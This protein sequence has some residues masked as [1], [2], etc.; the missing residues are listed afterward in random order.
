VAALPTQA[1]VRMSEVNR[2]VLFVVPSGTSFHTFF[3]S[4]ADAWRETGGDLAVAAGPDLPGQT[5]EWPEAVKRFPLPAF[6]GGNPWKLFAAGRRL[7]E[8]VTRWNP[9]IVHAHFAAGVVAAAVAKPVVGD[10][11]RRWVGTFHGLHMSMAGT[12]SVASRLTAT[13][14]RWAARRMDTVCVLNREDA[15][16]MRAILPRNRVH[17]VAS[18]GVG[19][20]LE[21][22]DPCHYP[23]KCRQDLR[24]RLGILPDSLVVAYVGRRTAFKGF[25]VAVRG[26]MRAGLE[27]A[28]LLLVGAPDDAHASGLSAA[29]RSTLAVDPRVVDAG[30]QWNVAP[31]LAVADICLLPSIREGLP[32][33][34]MEALAMG[35]PVVTIDARGCRDVV[36]DGIDGFVLPAAEADVIAN[37]LRTV[38][39][40]RDR[41]CRMATAAIAGRTRFDR[42]RYVAAELDLYSKELSLLDPHLSPQEVVAND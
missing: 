6:R 25:D 9:A 31:Y 24:T 14:E 7:A 28:S 41:L 20:D 3:R 33:T 19:C 17:V 34:A 2:R 42:R 36:R 39:A 29:E 10:R 22:F 38:S 40:N 16:A 8:V 26:F 30:W 35:V 11:R 12:R 4:V 27:Q 1:I 18:S 21:T 5:A 13:A 37:T 32:V 23:E 15:V